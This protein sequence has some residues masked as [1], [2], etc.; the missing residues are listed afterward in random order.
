MYTAEVEIKPDSVRPLILAAARL[1]MQGMVNAVLRQILN[2]EMSLLEDCRGSSVKP[3]RNKANVEFGLQRMVHDRE[4]Q[5]H[6]YNKKVKESYRQRQMN[7]NRCQEINCCGDVSEEG[8]DATDA[9]GPW[10]NYKLPQ[11]K[12]LTVTGI[13]DELRLQGDMNTL[14]Y[15]RTFAARSFSEVCETDAFLEASVHTVA[16][17]LDDDR[18]NLD[19]FQVFCALCRWLEAEQ[20][21]LVHAPYLLSKVRLQLLSPQELAEHVETK[22]YLMRKKK[23]R[24]NIL[25]AFRF[26]CLQSQS[27]PFNESLHSMEALLNQKPRSG[28]SKNYNSDEEWS[29]DE[30]GGLTKNDR[31]KPFCPINPCACCP[32]YILASGGIDTKQKVAS[33]GVYKYEERENSWLRFA[34]MQQPRNHHASVYC[35]GALYIIGGSDPSLTGPG[36]EVCPVSS[37][38]RLGLG[39]LKWCKIEAMSTPR[40][41]LQAAHMNDY[42]YAIGGQD[43]K[44]RILRDT[45]RYSLARGTWEYAGSLSS[46]RAG[47]AFCHYNKRLWVLGGYCHK[48]GI[49]LDKVEAYNEE[50]GNWEIMPSLRFPRCFASAAVCKQ[51]LYVLG[52]AWLDAEM[53][54]GN[55]SSVYDVDIYNPVNN[56]W[57]GITALRMGRHDAGLAVLGPRIYIVGGKH[58]DDG[59]IKNLDSVECFDVE[60]DDW[61]DGVTPLPLSLLGPSITYTC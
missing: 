57:E 56:C 37:C 41:S 27:G 1:E 38:Y 31:N 12:N 49:V 32:D 15:A 18:L 51:N 55:F 6:P 42:I 52:G 54:C 46:A 35:K 20:V 22:D 7:S 25:E 16:C 34:K 21:H 11:D 26:H 13:M 45:E 30:D 28:T 47:L 59:A 61:I 36:A 2:W 5:P 24:V 3:N 53:D 17:L 4:R 40:M 48:S 33:D 60:R 39:S 29:V 9:P 10:H 43:H 23:C 50:F 44:Q 8:S 19:E 58:C 14:A